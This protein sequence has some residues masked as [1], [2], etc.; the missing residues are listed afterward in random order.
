M[1]KCCRIDA[2]VLPF[3]ND[4]DFLKLCPGQVFA[5]FTCKVYSKKIFF[6]LNARVLW[7]I[8]EII[9]CPNVSIHTNNISNLHFVEVTQCCSSS[10]LCVR[11]CVDTHRQ[12]GRV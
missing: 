9:Q 3:L 4:D 7:M 12:A 10:C 8:P 1:G 11:V 2:F 5:I 6:G